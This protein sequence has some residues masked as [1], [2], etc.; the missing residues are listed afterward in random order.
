MLNFQREKSGKGVSMSFWR[1]RV[2]KSPL[3]ELSPIHSAA[4][5]A[6]IYVVFA[7]LYILLSGRIAAALAG[8]LENL[9]RIEAAK[10]LVFVAVTG[11][12]F[13]FISL[14]WWRRTRKQRELLARSERRAFASMYSAALAHD[15]NNLLMCLSGVVSGIRPLEGEDAQLAVM[16]ESVEASLNRLTPL[17]KRI[18]SS[19]RLSRED[20]FTEL[21]LAGFLEKTVEMARKHPDVR[22][23]HLSLGEVSKTVLNLNGDLFEQAL[24]NLI[25]NAAQAG[26]QRSRIE[27]QVRSGEEQTILEVH[28]DGPGVP[29][30][31][32]DRIFDTGYTSKKHG[33][34][35]GLLSVQ[36]FASSCQGKI[37][38]GRSSLGGALFRIQIP[39]RKTSLQ[40]PS[41]ALDM[42]DPLF[43]I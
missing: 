4:V 33:N 10:G 1:P 20:E 28:D 8:S 23:C 43:G 6:L 41:A 21:E 17:A 7:T 29:R 32:A 18:A 13:F 12:F 22:L 5:S 11:L 35:L 16:R 36:A 38:V 24:M 31:L 14:G 40:E 30:E 27:I 25:I 3:P 34:G 9:Q 42:G 26:G 15:L 39:N 2:F 37:S 19:A